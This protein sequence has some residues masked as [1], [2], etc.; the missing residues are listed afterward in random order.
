M[1]KDAPVKVGPRAFDILLVLL[2]RRG[3]LATKDE[4]IAEVWPGRVVEENNLQAQ[5][6]TLRK[7]LAGDADGER[8]LQTVPGRGYRFVALVEHERS[9]DEIAV[10][11]IATHKPPAARP[12]S[13]DKPSIAVVPFTNLSSDPRQ[14]YFSDGITDDI[15]TELSRFSELFVIASNSVF[16]FK[17]STLD[18]PQVG[19]ELGVHYV[20]EGSIRRVGDRVRITAKLVDAMIGAHRWAEHYDREMK[21]IFGVQDEVARTI[22]SILAA[23]VG[24]AEVERTRAK[25]PPTWQAYDYYLQGRDAFASFLTSYRAVDLYEMRGYSCRV[26]LRST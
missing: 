13:L 4:L 2:K 1:F 9:A 19:S 3:Q 10:T 14:L 5:I 17:G 7:V 20:L 6:S 11:A 22:V 21:N 24:K 26:H 23:H 12:P 25:P 16:K 8:Y 18:V 15:I